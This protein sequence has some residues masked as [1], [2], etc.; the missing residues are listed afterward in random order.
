MWLGRVSDEWE[1]K[2]KMNEGTEKKQVE[3]ISLGLINLEIGKQNFIQIFDEGIR[4]WGVWK[5]KT[6]LQ[7]DRKL[8]INPEIQAVS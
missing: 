7:M 4:V 6:L 1:K 8:Y 5:V 3:K 2:R